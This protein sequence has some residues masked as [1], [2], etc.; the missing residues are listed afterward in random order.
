MSKGCGRSHPH[1]LMDCC[2]EHKTEIARANN[3]SARQADEIAALKAELARAR[4]ALITTWT[5]QTLTYKYPT[6]ALMADEAVDR[7]KREIAQQID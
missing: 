3:L 6:R 5:G 1:E 2:C 7:Y 4:E